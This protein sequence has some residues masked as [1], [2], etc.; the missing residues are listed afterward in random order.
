MIVIYLQPH[1]T[2]LL[3]IKYAELDD[4]RP[5]AKFRKSLSPFHG[6]DVI[7]TI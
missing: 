4:L 3:W 6:I 5:A 1:L 2:V 7:T